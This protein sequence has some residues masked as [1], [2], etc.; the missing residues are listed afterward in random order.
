MQ[1]SRAD[2]RHT[3]TAGSCKWAARGARNRQGRRPRPGRQPA[4]AEGTADLCV[5][6]GREDEFGAGGLPD[7]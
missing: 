1:G 5:A 6:P 7:A 2:I 4:I 3:M